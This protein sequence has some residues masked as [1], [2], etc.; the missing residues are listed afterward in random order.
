MRYRLC[1]DS[2][3]FTANEGEI[4]ASSN[5]RPPIE[6]GNMS[7]DF[8]LHRGLG[9][10]MLMVGVRDVRIIPPRPAHLPAEG[11]IF[12]DTLICSLIQRF[13]LLHMNPSGLA[14]PVSCRATGSL[15]APSHDVVNHAQKVRF[16]PPPAGSLRWRPAHL[17]FLPHGSLRHQEYSRGETRDERSRTL[18]TA[19]VKVKP[20]M[21]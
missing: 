7:Q 12:H 3:I 14:D 13:P 16:D 2:Q 19:M 20:P 10:G 21:I 6:H 4:W 11:E 5:A 1:M 8:H 9:A 18:P 15:T 17:D